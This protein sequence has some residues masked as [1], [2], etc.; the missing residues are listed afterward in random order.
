MMSGILVKGLVLL[1]SGIVFGIG[2]FAAYSAL[3]ELKKRKTEK[4][5]SS[6]SKKEDIVDSKVK[7]QEA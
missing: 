7:T 6:E 5:N 4:L 2:E 3:D 1:V